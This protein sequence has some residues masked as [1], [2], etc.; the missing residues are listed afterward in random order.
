M[1]DLLAPGVLLVGVL[2]AVQGSLRC[3]KLI[4]ALAVFLDDAPAGT[5]GTGSVL[6]AK[7]AESV[8]SGPAFDVHIVAAGLAFFP[9]ARVF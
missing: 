4:V 6:T 5:L 7:E 2:E 3:Y 9:F 1:L 8:A